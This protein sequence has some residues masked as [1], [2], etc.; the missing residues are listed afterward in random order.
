MPTSGVKV[1]PYDTPDHRRILDAIIARYNYSHDRMSD[2]HDSWRKSE[3]A[4]LAYL[5]TSENDQ[6][7][8]N[9]FKQGS[10]Q[11]T[12]IVVPASYALMLAA[13]SYWS[14][15]FMSRD[16][17][18]QYKGRHGESAM[19]EQAVE[20]VMAYQYLAGEWAMPLYIWLYDAAKYGL[21][22]VCSYWEEEKKTISRIVEEPR[23]IMGVPILGKTHKV[24]KTEVIPGY[25]GNKLF[26]VRPFDFYPDPRKPIWDL[27]RSEFCGRVYDENWG[28]LIKGESDGRF[29]NLED[30]WRNVNLQSNRDEGSAQLKMPFDYH[31]MA[32]SSNIDDYN[33]GY[34]EVLEMFIDLIPADWGLGNRT[35]PEKWVF[36]VANEA[37]IFSAQPMGF[38]HDKFPFHT[39]PYELEGYQIATR[40]L[41]DITKP[42]NDTLT[43]LINSHFFNVRKAM[44][45]Q[46][47]IDPSRIEMRDVNNPGPGRMWRL[48]PAAYGSDPKTTYS[49]MLVNDVT[50]L[51]LQDA[52]IV[53]EMMQRLP[54][55]MD[56]LQGAPKTGGRKSATEMR[57]AAGFGSSRLKTNAEIMSASGWD[58]LAQIS[59]QATQQ[60]YT[61]EKIF[62]LVGALGEKYTEVRPED[63]AGFYDY[64]P[65]D[66]TLP[67]D[68][69]AQMAMWKELF[70][71]IA[72]MPQIAAR[73][74]LGRIFEYIAQLGGMRAITSFRLEI[75]PDAA[76]AAQAQ[77]GNVVPM[78]GQGGGPPGGRPQPGTRTGSNA[79]GVP[80][81]PQVAGMGPTG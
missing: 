79:T 3:E 65:V 43:W 42:L 34:V 55:V 51:N 68:R 71:E 53:M 77:A 48:K 81:A 31:S 72:A 33:K 4:V 54:G 12:T 67:A 8:K 9:L 36:L 16:P 64:Q 61:K 75:Q 35:R 80:G 18:F 73:Y 11:Y 56:N 32:L 50:R 22:V 30:V 24:T 46:L 23:Q 28:W 17:V 10:P 76:L 39:I 44:N 1:I 7:R 58:K 45:D 70:K 27:Q 26:N 62:R 60:M 2:F 19:Q 25:E 57:Q 29:Y 20:A 49:Q 40:G 37:V 6:L 59:L 15:V 21:G 69:F 52:Q 78:Q 38:Y 47:I 13:H 66:G 41:L 63:I 74:D 5:P 14:T